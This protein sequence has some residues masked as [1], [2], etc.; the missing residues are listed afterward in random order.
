[1][2]PSK[3]AACGPKPTYRQFKPPYRGYACN[4]FLIHN[5]TVNFSQG[6]EYMLYR[7][8]ICG[9][10]NYQLSTLDT[11]SCQRAATAE[12]EKRWSMYCW[13]ALTPWNTFVLFCSAQLIPAAKSSLQTQ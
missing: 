10:T 7:H 4:V 6:G 8:S 2:T 9:S 13:P 1:M 5:G 11:S 12:G 3:T